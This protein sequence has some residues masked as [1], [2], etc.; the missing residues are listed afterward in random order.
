[1]T[2]DNQI[3]PFGTS[4]LDGRGKVMSETIIL[5]MSDTDDDKWGRPVAK[6]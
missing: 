1:V 4:T 2:S 5:V 6:L 3:R